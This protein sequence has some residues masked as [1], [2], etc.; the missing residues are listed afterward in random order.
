LALRSLIYDG[1]FALVAGEDGQ[2]WVEAAE[3]LSAERG[4][5]LRAARVGVDKGDLIDIRLAWLKNRKITSTGA[6]LVRP[7]GVIGFRA[8]NGVEDPDAALASA[9]SRI[10]SISTD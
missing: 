8:I 10:L 7:D 6:V 2:S 5:P 9:L 1:H 3:K 4:I